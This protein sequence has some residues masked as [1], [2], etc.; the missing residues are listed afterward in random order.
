MYI[1]SISFSSVTSFPYTQLFFFFFCLQ[2][3]FYQLYVNTDRA[4]T[5]RLVHQAERGGCR[6]L[7]LTVDAPQLGRR[8]KD[9]RRKFTLAGTA[10]QSKDDKK[11][12]VDRNQ[13]I[14]RAISQFIDPSL[15]WS[16]IAWLRSITS[17][18]I[19]LK[20]VQRGED[21]VL[22]AKHGLA[23]VVCSNHGGRQLDFA[24]SGIEV[25]GEVMTALRAEGLQDKLEVFFECICFDFLSSHAYVFLSIREIVNECLRVYLA[26]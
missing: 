14:A 9:L 26:I 23:G 2:P 1:I 7:F 3:L 24:R 19:I 20:G 15:N 5:A 12:K 18:P 6:A 17:M 16:D 10:V 13:G 21:A 11:G 25:L 8:E 4:I 22:A